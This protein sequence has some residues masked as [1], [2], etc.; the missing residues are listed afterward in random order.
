MG[1]RRMG[2]NEKRMERN[3]IDEKTYT[4]PEFKWGVTIKDKRYVVAV[5]ITPESEYRCAVCGGELEYEKP[6]Q[7]D[8]A[9]EG[10]FKPYV[11]AFC[12]K[13]YSI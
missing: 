11:C 6:P 7:K 8:E 10:E 9:P 5:S 3:E 13:R 2:K 4:I 12:G 1:R